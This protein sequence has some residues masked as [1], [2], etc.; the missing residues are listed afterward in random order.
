MPGNKSAHVAVTY[1]GSGKAA[2]VKVYFDGKPQ[3]TNVENDKLQGSVKATVPFRLGA[4]TGGSPLSALQ[5]QD[6][7]IYKKQLNPG[8]VESLAKSSGFTSI[9]AKPSDKRSAKEKNDLYDWWL[10]SFDAAYK[11]TNDQISKAEA[12]L[13]KLK[14]SGTVAHVMQ[15]KPARR[16]P[17]FCIAASTINVATNN[18]QHARQPAAVPQRPARN[19]LGFAQWLLMPEHPLTARVTVNRMWQEIFGLGIV[20]TTGDFGVAG[21]LPINQPLLDW[22]AID[23][24]PTSGM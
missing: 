11:T 5:I 9:L 4:R 22:L 6:L 19:R 23:F 24:P 12:G 7:R 1:D 8:E 21:E 2:G 14:S 20:R 16:W 3:D 17:S 15:E 10:N 18:S 13:I